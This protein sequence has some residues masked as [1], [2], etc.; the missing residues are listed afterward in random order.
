MEN[1]PGRGSRTVYGNGVHE[2]TVPLLP[3]PD[4]DELADFYRM[5]GFDRTYRQVRPNPSIIVKREDLE[6]HFFGIDG[7]DPAESYGT[8][9]VIVPDTGALYTAFAE[10]MRA[11]HGKVLVS[12][13]PR[14]TRPR[15]RKNTGDVSGFSVVDPGGNWIRIFQ[16]TGEPA[17][18]PEASSKLGKVLQNAVVLG[19]SRGDPAQ[20]ARILDASLARHGESSPVTDRIEALVYRAELALTLGD[21]SRADDLLAQIRATELTDHDRTRLHDALANA[22]ALAQDRKPP[23]RREP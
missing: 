4:I 22:D 5:L 7:F 14:M 12:G 20:A 1:D 11:V 9:L 16:A 2:K 10:G 8:C 18:L 3:C 13:I 6:L 23:R 21:P 15:K 17:P 19:D